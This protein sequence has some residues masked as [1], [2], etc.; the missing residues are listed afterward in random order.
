MHLKEI[1]EYT[2]NHG[3]SDLHLTVGVPPIIRINGILQPSEFPILSPDDT[4]RIIFGILNDSQRVR[5]EQELELDV[6][7]FIPGL[8][9]FRV[10]VHLQK[11]CV[12]A[13]FRTI[14]MK[15]PPIDSLG[16]PPAATDLA[17]RPNGLVLITGPTGS[18]KSTTMAAMIDL[19]NRE[20]QC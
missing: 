13:A 14:P 6:S 3:A 16:L 15:I 7:L 17:R 11:G 2:V 10:N 20:R 12:E 5:F 1:L 9:R 19:I 18:G 8:S 4:K